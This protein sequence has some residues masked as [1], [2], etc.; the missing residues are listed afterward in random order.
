VKAFEKEQFIIL[1]SF[2]HWHHSQLIVFNILNMESAA[3][4]VVVAVNQIYYLLHISYICTSW[5]FV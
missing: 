5:L 1:H 4:L 3:N 2:C